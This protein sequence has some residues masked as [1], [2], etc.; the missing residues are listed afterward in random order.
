MKKF[1]ITLVVCLIFLIQGCFNT[2]A[3]ERKVNASQLE[4]RI[5]NIN[6]P[7]TIK[8]SDVRNEVVKFLINKNFSW[9]SSK[10]SASL[11]ASESHEVPEI[12]RVLVEPV[13]P[14]FWKKIPIRKNKT[15]RVCAIIFT[16]F[17]GTNVVAVTT[18]EKVWVPATKAV[19]KNVVR[20]V[21]KVF[22][23]IYRVGAWVKADASF[24]GLDIKF[25]NNQAIVK[26]NTDIKLSVD[27]ERNLIP[28][29]P[30]IK[31]KGIPTGTLKAELVSVSDVNILPDGRIE[32]S[33]RPRLEKIGYHSKI[34]PSSFSGIDFLSLINPQIIIFNKKI[35]KEILDRINDKVFS[36]GYISRFNLNDDIHK[37]AEKISEP[38]KIGENLWL[39][40]DVKEISLGSLKGYG[41]GLNNALSLNVGLKMLSSVV[42]GSKPYPQPIRNKLFVVNNVEKPFF[43]LNAR[44][45]LEYDSFAK[46]LKSDIAPLV[47]K[48]KIGFIS[49][50]VSDIQIYPSGEKIVIAVEV[51]NKDNAYIIGRFYLTGVIDNDFDGK[52]VSFKDVKFTSDTRTSIG[53]FS[54]LLDPVI[55]EKIKQSSK[56]SYK[57]KF[58]D[59]KERIGQYGADLGFGYIQAEIKKIDF[60][61]ISLGEKGL[62]LDLSINGEAKFN[63][64]FKNLVRNFNGFQPSVSDEDFAELVIHHGD[65]VFDNK[66]NTYKADISS[67]TLPGEMIYVTDNHGVQDIYINK[68]YNSYDEHKKLW[69][70]EDFYNINV[71]EVIPSSGVVNKIMSHSKFDDMVIDQLLTDN[72]LASTKMNM[73]CDLNAR[74]YKI[75][76]NM[77]NGDDY[78]AL[79]SNMACGNDETVNYFDYENFHSMVKEKMIKATGGN[80]L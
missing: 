30:H 8:A 26:V 46:R 18:Y 56:I 35:K 53:M 68:I 20:P 78:T 2:E 3:P 58:N 73:E 51:I 75:I 29:G 69:L 59:L 33:T 76:I 23:K 36:D 63:V 21:V 19:Y 37:M 27:Y 15:V 77:M 70:N 80:V 22:D 25:V 12:L 62:F 5:S 71:Y 4:Q 79:S 39:N 65:A 54:S 16:L 50:Q 43:N 32:L 1:L 10:L 11:L 61:K 49:P 74:Y 55:E 45:V 14:G 42:Y 67:I 13:K 72:L 38:N 6:I 44:V 28:L 9:K 48:K 34:L 7:M 64:A 66:G 57:K 24:T 40:N 17:C 52:F 47:A 60:S 31:I 41:E